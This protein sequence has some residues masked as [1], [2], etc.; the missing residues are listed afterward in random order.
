M[1][2]ADKLEAKRLAA[3]LVGKVNTDA[4]VARNQQSVREQK[5]KATKE[6][7]VQQRGVSITFA[8]LCVILTGA[9]VLWVNECTRNEEKLREKALGVLRNYAGRHEDLGDENIF[10]AVRT[11][12][13]TLQRSFL[14]AVGCRV[15]NDSFMVNALAGY[16]GPFRAALQDA[17]KQDMFM[18]AIV[19]A[20]LVLFT[21]SVLVLLNSSC[22]SWLWCGRRAPK[23]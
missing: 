9:L 14:F 15:V 6:Y 20:I 7:Y 8:A 5:R 19:I 10:R 22:T 1:M 17:L 18:L 11:A 21:I 16:E 2:T 4:L 12:E 3:E 13:D 23:N